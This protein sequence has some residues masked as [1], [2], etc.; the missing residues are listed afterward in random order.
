[1]KRL[2][3]SLYQI[4]FILIISNCSN[5][6]GDVRE[7]KVS[8]LVEDLESIPF[9]NWGQRLEKHHAFPAKTNVHFLKI[10]SANQ[11][12]IR[13]WER[14]SGPT[15]ACGT[16]ACAS[17]VAACLLGLSDDHAQVL[18]LDELLELGACLLAIRVVLE[19]G[20]RGQV[21]GKLAQC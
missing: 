8:I 2:L 9:E 3:I 17:L 21:L 20:Y 19:G 13:V 5:Q 6:I 7:N 11:L 4:P 12:E 18:A 14:G 15:L 16:G 1:M 10:H